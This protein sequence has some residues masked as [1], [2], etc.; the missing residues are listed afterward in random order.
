MKPQ[1]PVFKKGANIGVFNYLFQQ[2]AEACEYPQK[3]WVSTYCNLLE[4]RH[5][6][7]ATIYTKQ[8]PECTFEDLRGHMEGPKSDTQSDQASQIRF[9][10][11]KPKRPEDAAA[12]AEESA[13]LGYTAYSGDNRDGHIWTAAQIDKLVL[14]CFLENLGG[15][16]GAK[17]NEHFPRTMNEAVE[18]AKNFVTR[19]LTPGYDDVGLTVSYVQRGRGGAVLRGATRGGR[20]G[21]LGRVGGGGRISAPIWKPPAAASATLN[22][23]KETRACH[24]CGRQGHLIKDCF[25]KKREEKTGDRTGGKDRRMGKEGRRGGERQDDRPNPSST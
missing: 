18:L 9:K 22:K 23:E 19:G 8:H 2:Q 4:G 7:K 13:N 10:T 14:D 11:R 6:H 21:T 20:G 24:Y 15:D 17:V 1:W 12:F 25:K 16:L 3:M 5:Q